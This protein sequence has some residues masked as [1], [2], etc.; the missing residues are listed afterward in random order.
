MEG[1]AHYSVSYCSFCCDRVWQKQLEAMCGSSV[2][3]CWLDTNW[4]NSRRRSLNRRSY[5]IRLPV[6]TSL[7]ALD[8]FM[9]DMRWPSSLC[10][11]SLG[12]KEKQDEEVMEDY[13][14]KQNSFIHGLYFHICLQVPVTTSFHEILKAVRWSIL[15]FFSGMPKC[16]FPKWCWVLLQLLNNYLIILVTK[17]K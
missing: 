5:S 13:N 4:R 8:W 7:V 14:S 9:F 17:Y 11:L 6:G 16:L 10:G 12:G 15:F 3:F 2:C 1:Q